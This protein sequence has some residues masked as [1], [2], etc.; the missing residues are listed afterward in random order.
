MWCKEIGGG[1]VAYG[2]IHQDIFDSTLAR[3]VKAR[4]LFQDLIILADE[5]DNVMMD[6]EDIVHRTRAPLEDVREAVEYLLKADPMSKSSISK[7]ARITAILGTGGVTIGYHIV[8]RHY[9][10][11]LMSRVRRREYMRRYRAELLDATGTPP[12]P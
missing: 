11:R 8:N 2:V 12:G 1:G 3:N 5:G 7:G 10:K 4:W 9:Y 6:V